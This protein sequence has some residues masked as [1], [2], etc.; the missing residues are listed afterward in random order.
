MGDIDLLDASEPAE[1]PELVPT[2]PASSADKQQVDKGNSQQREEFS[3]LRKP[4]M[5]KE[6][7]LTDVTLIGQLYN[8]PNWSLTCMS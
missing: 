8:L 2:A 7:V 3:T 5:S 4:K 6:S 1:T